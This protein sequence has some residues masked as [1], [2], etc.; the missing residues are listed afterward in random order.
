MGPRSRFGVLGLR[1]SLPACDASRFDVAMFFYP[2]A[3]V[4]GALRLTVRSTSGY[5][6]KFVKPSA[7]VFGCVS[8]AKGCVS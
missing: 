8:V 1:R 5:K 7:L 6:N 4:Y 2:H 3:A